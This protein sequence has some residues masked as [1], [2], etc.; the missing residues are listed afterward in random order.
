VITRWLG[1]RRF[2]HEWDTT[3]RTVRMSL[4]A[5][6]VEIVDAQ[7]EY[8]THP[9]SARICGQIWGDMTDL[10]YP[11]KENTDHGNTGKRPQPRRSL[12]R[13]CS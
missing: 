5:A 12:R 6:T 9:E 13:G 10:M 8:L 2:R 1:R 3:A 7:T 4:A 11:T